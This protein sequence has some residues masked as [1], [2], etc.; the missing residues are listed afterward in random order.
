ML[1]LKHGKAEN[2]NTTRNWSELKLPDSLAEGADTCVRRLVVEDKE[3]PKGYLPTNGIVPH[4]YW[5]GTIKR[6]HAD[7]YV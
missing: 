4:L 7:L 2:M 5:E 6:I 1:R 3:L